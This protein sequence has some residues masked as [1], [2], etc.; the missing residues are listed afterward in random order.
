MEGIDIILQ[1]NTIRCREDE[2][3]RQVD[4]V[5]FFWVLPGSKTSDRYLLANLTLLRFWAVFLSLY[6][7]E[8]IEIAMSYQIFSL[9]SMKI[10]N[11]YSK[12]FLKTKYLGIHYMRHFYFHGIEL[13]R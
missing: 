6:P 8:C 10:C 9:D 13:Y 4:S 12:R 3:D 7:V 1:I 2:L 11:S 5:G